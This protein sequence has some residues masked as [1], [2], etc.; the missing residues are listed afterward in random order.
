[1][2]IYIAARFRVK[3]T[4]HIFTFTFEQRVN[5]MQALGSNDYDK[6]LENCYA[7]C[8]FG[9]AKDIEDSFITGILLFFWRFYHFD[10]RFKKIFK[11]PT[12]R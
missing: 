1:M 11:N 5:H 9:L 8:S 7:S 4:T 12:E 3:Y 10:S 2:S 6:I